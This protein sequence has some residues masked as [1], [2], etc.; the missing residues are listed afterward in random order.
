MPRKRMNNEEAKLILQAYR[1]GG[2][3]AH[4]PRFQEALEQTGRD[5]ELGRWLAHEQALDSRISNQL[6]SALQPPPFLKAR[7]LAQRV[8]AP[9]VARWRQ[10]FWQLAAA[11]CVLLLVT[12]AVLRSGQGRSSQLAQFRDEMATFAGK[13]L[14][15]FDLV[16]GDVEEVRR[17]LGSKQ[18]HENLI[19][20]AGL[21]GRTSL[22]CRLLDWRGHTVS[23][24]CFEL[25]NQQV[26]HLLV[27]DSAAF[28]EAPP[29]NPTF[30]RVGDVG[31]MSWSRDGKT[32]VLASKGADNTRLL[33]LL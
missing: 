9:P 32:Y 6:R 22:G 11:A 10:P 18:A 5:P 20:P 13:R 29:A 8:T 30:V 4:D 26:A 7:L 12:L 3:D 19:L 28:P 27:V 33:S 31:S 25:G 15:R 24:I 21:N 14:D 17:W 16:S 1:P 23:L 2:P